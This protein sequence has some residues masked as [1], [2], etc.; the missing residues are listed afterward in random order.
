MQLIV[1]ECYCNV[2]FGFDAI[3]A[4]LHGPNHIKTEI[5]VTVTPCKNK[6]NYLMVLVLSD[7]NPQYT[8][9][10]LLPNDIPNTEVLIS[11]IRGSCCCKI[12][13]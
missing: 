4:V 3:W 11:D 2:D 12:I 13:S 1:A 8:Y 9:K 5:N 6:L 10:I 7:F